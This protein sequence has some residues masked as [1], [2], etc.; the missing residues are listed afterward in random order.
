M[1]NDVKID[2][3]EKGWNS[4]DWINLAQDR[5]QWQAFMNTVKNILVLSN[6]GNFLPS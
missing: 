6:A 4:V 3:K 5:V 2:P 1:G